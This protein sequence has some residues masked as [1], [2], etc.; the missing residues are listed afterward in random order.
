MSVLQDISLLKYTNK[1]RVHSLAEFV[2]NIQLIMPLMDKLANL[3][4]FIKDKDAQYKIVNQ[5]MIDRLGKKNITELID[6]KAEDIFPRGLGENYTEQD[7]VVL[8]VEYSIINRLEIHCYSFGNLGWCITTKIPIIANGEVV[9]LV[10]ISI[11][12]QD[13]ESV[14]STF[15]HNLLKIERYINENIDGDLSV[16]HLSDLVQLSTSQLNR[17]FQTVLRISPQQYI[18]KIR[19]QK[20]IELLMQDVSITEISLSCGYSD[21]SAFTRK[22]KQITTMTPSQFKT[23]LIST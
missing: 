15:S 9:G 3:T 5:T 21:H 19:F 6:K 8:T 14:T 23:M 4:F 22:F 17:Q 20:A 18:Q 7:K 10:G 13:N 1:I 12:I 11:D 16:S 2:N